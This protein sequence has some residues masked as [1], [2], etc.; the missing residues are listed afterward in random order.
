MKIIKEEYTLPFCSQ[1]Q[2]NDRRNRINLLQEYNN[3]DA[4]D[5]DKKYY[6][7]KQMFFSIGD[8][9]EIVTPF[10]ASWGGKNVI[11]GDNCCINFNV[12]MIDDGKIEIGNNVLIGPNVT[13]S[14]V[15]HPIKVE[16]R[17][18]NLLQIENVTI[19]DNVWIGSNSVILPG[20]KIGKNSVIGAGS[21]VTKDIPSNVLAFGNP[22]KII[23]IIN[24]KL[25]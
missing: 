25:D 4:H 14:T 13:I 21:V 12:T 20:I 10:Y 24:E 23:K 17:I 2:L 11:I 5:I 9:T 16:D 22:C 18:K 3:T 1:E 15:N 8:E 7:K 19:E 6:L